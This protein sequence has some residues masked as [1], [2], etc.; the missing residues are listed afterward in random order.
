MEHTPGHKDCPACRKHLVAESP[1]A[2][3]LVYPV[4]SR[5]W[6]ELRQFNAGSARAGYVSARTLKDFEDYDKPLCRFFEELTLEEIH[7][8]HLRQYQHERAAGKLGPG[9]KELL[10]VYLRRTAKKLCISIKEV[11]ANPG[12]MAGI[13]A[14]IESLPP[15]EISPNKIN[16]ELSM[17]KRIM[18]RAG[19]WTAEMEDHY[20]PL[21][22]IESDIPRALTP[23]EQEHFL[24]EARAR[25]EFVYCYAILGI[26]AVLSTIEER[27]LKLG[28]INLDQGTVMIRSGSAKNKYRI[29]TNPLTDQA[30]WAVERMLERARSLGS[31]EPQHY[32]MPFRNARNQFDPGR[33]MT[34]SGIKK[35]WNEIREAAGVEWFTQ[36]GLRHTG[37]TRYAEDGTAIPV[38]MSLAGHMTRRMQ[39]HYTHISEAAKRRATQQRTSLVKKPPTSVGDGGTKSSNGSETKPSFRQVSTQ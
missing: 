16:Q 36:Y 6:I 37:C 38:L 26:D 5:Q 21:R 11:E 18:R 10:P 32:L 35:P 33:P 25:N 31:I 12:A 19:V 39:E 28:D 7:A 9:V 27:S 4:A 3:S 8:G 1:I 13:K 14:Y 20:Q 17:L 2:R 23:A 15:R 30:K 22:N 29:R 24:N 34:G